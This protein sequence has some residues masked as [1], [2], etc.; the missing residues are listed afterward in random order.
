MMFSLLQPVLRHVI[1]TLG[2]DLRST[3][4]AEASNAGL[5]GPEPDDSIVEASEVAHLPQPVRR[6]L[7]FMGVVGAPRVWSVEARFRGRFN[8]Q[9]R[10]WMRAEAWQYN[11][12]HPVGRV[13]HMRLDLVGVVPVVGRDTYLGDEG[14]MVGRLLG[15][16]PV[17]DGRGR[18]F[19]I[20]EL[21]TWLNDALILAPSML[22]TDA[23]TWDAV[24][25]DSFDVTLAHAGVTVTGRVFLDELGSMRDFSSR[26]RWA[27]L[28]GGL[29]QAEWRTPLEEWGDVAG[30][31][32][33]IMGEAVWHLDDGPL[34]YV[35]G[36]F[37][38]DSVR[39]NHRP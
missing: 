39:V 32:L 8:L 14:R 25:D 2:H 34:T 23:V 37:V 12:A 26:D 19:D 21:T 7:D 16:V 1:E 35:E 38:P 13:F 33:P 31:R 24:D 15:V 4:R 30:H 36:A 3:A 28:P 6:Y 11:C 27:D 20:G 9:G 22:L 10:G 29:V 17:A 5:P 18:A